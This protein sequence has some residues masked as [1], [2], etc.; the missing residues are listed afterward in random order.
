MLNN[1]NPLLSKAYL[2]YLN[3]NHFKMVEAMRLIIHFG[4]PLNGIM[5]LPNLMKIYQVVQKLIGRDKQA[6]IS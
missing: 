2:T 6:Q 1:P 3:L 5:S 4:A